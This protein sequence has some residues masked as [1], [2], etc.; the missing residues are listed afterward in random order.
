MYDVSREIIKEFYLRKRRCD[1]M[2]YKIH[3]INDLT[4]HHLLISRAECKLQRIPQEGYVNWNGVLLV[5]DTSHDYLHIIEDR[6]EEIFYK[7]TSE[8]LD[9]RIQGRITK[10][11]LKNIRE[12]LLWF[13]SEHRNDKN[14]KGKILIKEKF[15]TDRIDL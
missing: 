15:Y 6:D 5:R 10:E 14:S 2:G 1:F 12:L 13:E 8:L 4:F 11:H 7:I 9:E 3:S